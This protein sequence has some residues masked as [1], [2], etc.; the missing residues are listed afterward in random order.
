VCVCVCFIDPHSLD[1]ELLAV[2]EGE[3]MVGERAQ[4]DGGVYHVLLEAQQAHVESLEP[5]Q[6]GVLW[7]AGRQHRATPTPFNVQYI[8]DV[9]NIISRQPCN[10]YARRAVQ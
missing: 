3:D 7:R 6:H 1:P 2:A 4:Y 8:R 5:H 10:N 9:C